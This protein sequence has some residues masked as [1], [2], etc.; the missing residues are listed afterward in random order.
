MQPIYDM[1]IGGMMALLLTLAVPFLLIGLLM[2]I[3]LK[4]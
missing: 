2:Y 3:L 4:D 1:V